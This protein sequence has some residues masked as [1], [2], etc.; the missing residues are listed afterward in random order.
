MELQEL[1]KALAAEAKAAGICSEWYDFILNADSKD[2]L[3][4][5]YYKGFDFVEKKNF[6]SERLRREFDDIRRNYGIYEAEVFCA[7]NPRR[8]VA[9]KGASG[10][11]EYDNFAAAQLWARPGSEVSITARDNAFATVDVAEGARV[12]IKASDY[13]RVI[14]FL[15]GGTL[16]HTAT[17]T[18]RIKIINKQ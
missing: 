9:Y 11:A 18:A 16:T 15:H 3:I 12:D 2:R 7:K 14:V 8:L 10:S 4:T 6:P 13:A 1:K 17:G 5:L